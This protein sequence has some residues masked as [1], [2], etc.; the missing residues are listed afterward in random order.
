MRLNFAVRGRGISGRRPER[1]SRIT[2]R[3]CSAS[4][5]GQAE[6]D[7]APST[8][9]NSGTQIGFTLLELIIVLTILSVLTAAA[10]PMVRNTVIRERESELRL[11][12]RQLRQAI[13]RYK[14]L[15]DDTNGAAIPIEF[16][17]QSGYPKDLKVLEEGFIP[18]NVVGTSSN[19]IRFIRRIPVDPTTGR[20]EWGLR[21][22]KDDPDATSWGGDD[23]WDV[24][25]K[26][27]GTALNGTRYRDW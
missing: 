21:G 6:A 18:A 5:P 17:T 23:V 8:I 20:A 16:K 7:A 15:H 1:E 13:D 12:L 3:R 11:A 24:R 2:G 10:I 14:K 22:Y 25:S 27:D 19:K 4:D 9:R 26:S